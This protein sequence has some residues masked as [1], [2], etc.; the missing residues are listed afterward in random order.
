M[1]GTYRSRDLDDDFMPRC[2]VDESIFAECSE[3]KEETGRHPNVDGLD[4]G[5]PR[6]IGVDANAM[7]RHR[8]YGQ[9]AERHAGGGGVHVDPKRHPRQ[10]DNKNTRN[11]QLDE[12]VSQV[13]T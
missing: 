9:Q 6:E 1:G 7:V 10:D 3:D 12:V 13:P 8:Q 2:H 11:E 4:V 5:D